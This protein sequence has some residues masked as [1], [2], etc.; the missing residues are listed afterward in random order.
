[1]SSFYYIA[2]VF[3]PKRQ[4]AILMKKG[5]LITE[6]LGVS[7]PTTVTLSL[8]V[9]RWSKGISNASLYQYDSLHFYPITELRV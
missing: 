7:F 6:V 2:M 5:F 3:S 1:M 8:L 9:E 4:I